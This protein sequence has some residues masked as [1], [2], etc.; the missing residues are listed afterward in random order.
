LQRQGLPLGV[1]DYL[2]AL[3]ALRAGF[4]SGGRRQLRQLCEALW[5]R[6]EEEARLVSLLFADF[7]YPSAEEVRKLS[8]SGEGAAAQPSEAAAGAGASRPREMVETPDQEP[9]ALP[10]DF[11]PASAPGGIDIPRAE[12]PLATAEAFVLSERPVIP[13]RSLITAWRRFRRPLRAGPPVDLDVDATIAAKCRTGLVTEPVLVPARRN[14]VALTVLVDV[15]D[16]MLPWSGFPAVLIESL[17]QG[18]LGAVALYYFANVPANPLFRE[19]RLFRPMTLAAALAADSDS[20]LLIVSDAGAVRNRYT[21]RRVRE[22][23]DFL[24]AVRPHWS[25]VAWLN[26]MPR[27]RWHGSSAARI[28][29][30]PGVSM[31]ELTEDGVVEA[32]DVLRGYGT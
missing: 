21:P 4:G 2:D 8:P 3:R 6:T 31:H 30:L 18:Q 10:L 12:A 28:A 1:R 25:P 23:A 5:A 29:G 32:V 27:P 9:E 7:P 15:S 26:P 13:V 20:S 17:A 16:S 14:Q 22:T 19:F 24:R 11:V